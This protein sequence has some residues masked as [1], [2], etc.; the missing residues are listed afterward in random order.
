[1]ADDNFKPVGVAIEDVVN[2][3]ENDSRISVEH[4]YN[5]IKNAA[6]QAAARSHITLD[7][8]L[9]RHQVTQLGKSRYIEALKRKRKQKSEKP[10][11][12]NAWIRFFEAIQVDIGDLIRIE[13]L[14]NTWPPFS[15]VRFYAGEHVGTFNGRNSDLNDVQ[16]LSAHDCQSIE[17][18][19]GFLGD[20]V[21]NI[22]FET[23][24][25]R[26]PLSFDEDQ[27]REVWGK[28]ES[29]QVEKS[30]P[31]VVAE[32]AIGSPASCFKAKELS[33]IAWGNLT[34]AERNN[35]PTLQMNLSG[36]EPNGFFKQ[37]EP[38]SEEM[39]L[40][41]RTEF[42]KKDTGNEVVDYGLLI[43]DKTECSRW[44]HHPSLGLKAV[45]GGITHWGSIAAALEFAS[46]HW[47]PWFQSNSKIDGC[48]C[49]N[50]VMVVLL[51]ID[52]REPLSTSFFDSS[53]VNV[54][55]LQGGVLPSARQAL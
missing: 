52:V 18:V 26:S 6:K 41:G 46:G 16:L 50:E 3:I 29:L 4:C 39:A 44:P 21:E 53:S 1:M 43:I 37:A 14:L 51:K 34:D 25:L 48:F 9:S 36:G 42:K 2:L 40:F 49:T 23:E 10:A 17:M 35:V 7:Q 30:P 54:T 8:L 28:N 15:T 38:G 31:P 32:V 11:L 33:D 47:V 12:R 5:A 22:Y 20:H 27:F 24:Y 45:V 19:K 55:R 13:R